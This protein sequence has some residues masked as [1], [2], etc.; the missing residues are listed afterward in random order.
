MPSPSSLPTVVNPPAKG[1]SKQEAPKLGG[2]LPPMGVPAKPV[3]KR[4]VQ[5]MSNLAA[6]Y[7]ST[8]VKDGTILNRPRVNRAP[9]QTPR[10]KDGTI[11][12][13][14]PLPGR[15]APRRPTR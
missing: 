2:E 3:R 5:V 8:P 1:K 12:P 9:D 6:P 13:R 15:S 4:P 10:V 14:N 11:Y 7:G